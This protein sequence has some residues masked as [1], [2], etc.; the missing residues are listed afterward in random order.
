MG[1]RLR[2]TDLRDLTENYFNKDVLAWWVRL[3]ELIVPEHKAELVDHRAEKLL[4]D[5]EQKMQGPKKLVVVNQWHM[6]QVERLWRLNHGISVDRPPTSGTEDMPLG[7]I[8]AYIK[9]MKLDRKKTE[10]IAGTPMALPHDFQIVPYHD[11]NRSHC[12]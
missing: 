6:D 11:Q 1:R 5:I 10:E 4:T 9:G 7:A 2:L 12:A 3:A 8:Q